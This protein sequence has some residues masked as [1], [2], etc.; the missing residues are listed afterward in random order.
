LRAAELLKLAERESQRLRRHLLVAAAIREAFETE[1][2]VVG[3]T[4]EEFWTAAEYHQ[5]D[6]DLCVPMGRKEHQALKELGFERHRGARHWYHERAKVAVEFPS[7]FIDGDLDRV[8]R[9]EIGGGVAVIIGLDDLYID[10][11]RQAT[12]T[13]LTTRVEFKSALAVASARFEA[14]DWKHVSRRISSITKTEPSVGVEMKRLNSLIR[15]QVRKA[16][17]EP[18]G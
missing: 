9:E 8:H 2:V 6:L 12:T 3:G 5:T 14:I 4:A 13:G 16:L 10:R 15:R 11:L 1:P 18:S 17:T 7:S